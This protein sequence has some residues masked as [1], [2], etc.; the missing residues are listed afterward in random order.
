MRIPTTIALTTIA[1]AVGLALAGLA[2]A[3]AAAVTAALGGGALARHAGRTAAAVGLMVLSAVFAV[4]VFDRL[5]RT[6]LVPAYPSLAAFPDNPVYAACLATLSA[7]SSG[8]DHARRPA[9]EPS[10]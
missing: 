6:A 3:F 7:V 8:L 5:F 4:I 1:A 9:S 10:A 2:P